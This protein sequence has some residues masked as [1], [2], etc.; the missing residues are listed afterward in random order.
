MITVEE[1]VRVL[2]KFKYAKDGS[3]Y[4]YEIRS[5]LI[6]RVGLGPVGA[7][8]REVHAAPERVNI[9]VVRFDNIKPEEF[10]LLCDPA[11]R[12][13]EPNGA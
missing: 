13:E 2:E 11:Q 12:W 8:F 5:G 10:K 4:V 1:A 6:R 9:H 7:T 3:T